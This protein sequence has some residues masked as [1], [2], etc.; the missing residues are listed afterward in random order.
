[1]SNID[2]K[3]Y[4]KH[5]EYLNKRYGVFLDGK[6]LLE[7]INDNGNVMSEP[8]FQRLNKDGYSLPVGIMPTKKGKWLF[9]ID[10]VVRWW[11]KID[12]Q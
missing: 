7:F 9:G 5:W 8:T 2:F 10:A 12:K 3:I 11:L 6:D 1:M 4:E